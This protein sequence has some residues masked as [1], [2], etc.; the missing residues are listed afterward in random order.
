MIRKFFFSLFFLLTGNIVAF[1]D[2]VTLGK[3]KVTVDFSDA[4]IAHEGPYVV[5]RGVGRYGQKVVVGK[6]TKTFWTDKNQPDASM[7]YQIE[8]AQGRLV[9]TLAHELDM[10]GP[11][12][13]IFRP[14]DSMDSV[15]SVVERIHTRMFSDDFGTGRYAILFQPGDYRKAGLL[16]VPFYV[17]MAGLGRTPYDVQVH[18]I[19]TPVHLANDNGTCTFWRSLENLSVLGPMTYEEDETFKWAV[20]QAAPI[21]RVFSERTVRNQWKNGWVSGGFTADCNFMA[22]A[23][24]HGQQQ[25][26]TRNTHLEY[27][28]GEFAE[29]SWNFM[30]QGVELGEKANLSTYVNNWDM[31]GNV[32]FIPTTPVIREKPFLFVDE[33]GQYKV[34]RPALRRNAVGVSY[35]REDMGAGQIYDVATEFYIAAPGVR[36]AEIN[37]QLAQGKHILFQPGMYQ[38]EEPIRVTRPETIVMGLGWTTLI[39]GEQNPESALIVSDVDG[40]TLCSLL[41]DAHYSSRTLVKLE[42]KGAS[43][44]ENPT[45]LAD[46][47]FRVGGFRPAPV[48]V[49]CALDI[50]NN[51]VI[52]DHFWIWRADHGVKGSVGWEVNTAPVGLHVTGDDVT[53]YGLFNEH[54]QQYQTYWEGER[55][56][57]FFYQCETPYDALHQERYMS[58]NGTRAGYAAYKVS[59]KVNIHQAAGLGIYDVYFKTDIRMENSMEV[60][61]KPGIR[62]YHLCNVSL[63]DPGDRGIG[64]VINGKVKSTYNT[65]RVC[66]PW[67]DEFVGGKINIHSQ[68]Q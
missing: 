66:R 33:Q 9:A 16:K 1:A 38:L 62:I 37:R 45:L 68:E 18:N 44:E 13:H 23:G 50:E 52:G 55:G 47:F 2:G 42:G 25:W 10:F 40:V 15:H 12:V 4:A 6:T 48:H 51:H 49:D 14:S 29:G 56:N 36:A 54:F 30:F 32:T 24:S 27:G 35:S 7:Y 3:G 59:D 61:E 58:E 28:R 17:H 31:G 22:P 60:P 43:H 65:F 19:H 53:V 63:S 67:I 26:Y 11:D 34:F 39:P 57:T 21:R 20:S 41:F 8:D 5:K 64:Y 46:L